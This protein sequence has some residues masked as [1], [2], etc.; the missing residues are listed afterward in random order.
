MEIR[1]ATFDDV[2]EIIE[3][4]KR[5]HAASDNARFKFNEAKAKLLCAQ[6]I[7]GKTTCLFVAVDNGKIVGIL[8]GQTEEYVYCNMRYA[9]DIALYAEAP[10]A[11]R[12]L[13][14]R[15]EKWAF[16]EKKV[17]QLLMGVSF[18]AGQNRQAEAMYRRR[19]F[20]HVGGIF[21][22]NREPA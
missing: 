2:P 14:K 19:G 12:A 15:F 1:E 18:K 7:V 9:T 20:A 10:G 3:I 16:D 21:T 22:K 13:L 17:D 6:L 5:G 8:L 4:G 11:G